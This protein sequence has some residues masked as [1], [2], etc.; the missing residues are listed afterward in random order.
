MSST[1]ELTAEQAERLKKQR[2]LQ[3][4]ED[5]I[6]DQF[7]FDNL[8]RST[9]RCNMHFCEI[10]Q[11]IRGLFDLHEGRIH[12]LEELLKLRNLTVGRYSKEV[13]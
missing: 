2:K 3:D 7:T 5:A 9:Q 11:H 4:R 6:L 8:P 1:K 13:V 10:A 12:Y